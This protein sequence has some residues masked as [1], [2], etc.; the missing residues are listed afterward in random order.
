MIND[1]E[2][3]LL[4]DDKHE[5]TSDLFELIKFNTN[6]IHNLQSEILVVASSKQFTFI[7]TKKAEI[8]KYKLNDLDSLNYAYSLKPN[9][10]I[11]IPEEKK[12]KFNDDL[13]HIWTDQLGNHVIIKFEHR[14]FYFNKLLQNPFELVSLNDIEIYAVA[15]DERNKDEKTTQ[16]ILISDQNSI[17]YSYKISIEE[18]KKDFSVKE[19]Q[20]KKLFEPENISKDDRI[21]SIYFTANKRINNP[22]YYII[23]VT[24]T[25]FFQFEGK[26]DFEFVFD[27]YNHKSEEN[28]KNLEN[29]CKIFP[30]SLK[31][32]S[33]KKSDL[34]ILYDKDGPNFKHFGWLCESGFC[35]GNFKGNEVPEQVQNFVILPYVKIKKDGIRVDDFPISFCIS[36]NHIFI[37]YSDCLTVLSKIT[38]NIIHTQYFTNENF[39]GM[40]YNN[41]NDEK[42]I[43]I[44]SLNSGLYQ[45]SLKDEDKNVWQ[46]YLE[47][48]DYEK[49][50]NFCHT[51][52]P[53]IEPKICKLS[54]NE[55]FEKGDYNNA[56]IKYGLSDEKFEEVCLKFLLKNELGGLKN[57]LNVIEKTR[58][59]DKDITQKYL[60]HTWL[61]EIYLNSTSNNKKNNIEEF[62]QMVSENSKYLDKDTIYQLL[63]N[64]GRVEEFIEFAE[65]KDDYE[66]VILHYINEKDVDTAIEKLI[67]YISYCGDDEAVLKK[68][69]EIFVKFAHIFMKSNHKKSIEILQN[70][71]QKIKPEQIITA[72]MNT[73]ENNQKIEDFQDILKYL[74]ELVEDPNIKDKNIHN[75][76]IFYLS[77]S[78]D[79]YHS[80]LI[81][82]LEKPLKK[83]QNERRNKPKT[84]ILFEL[85]YAKKLFKENY[86]ALALVL[87]LMG[88]YNEGVKIALENDKNEIAKFIASNVSDEKI[89]KSLW[90]D[91]FSANKKNNFKDALE[92]MKTSQ[93]LKIEDVLPRI[94]D[95]IKI[96]EF[97]SQ[98][99]ECID[100]YEKNIKELRDDIKEYNKTAE[101][102]KNDINKVK[103]KSLEIQYRQCKCEICQCNIKDN[104]IYL[105][106]CG[107]M[108]D[109]KCI[110]DSLINYQKNMPN[111]ENLKDKVDKI[112]DLQKNINE[113]EKKFFKKQTVDESKKTTGV[114]GFFNFQTKTGK[115]NSELNEVD[116]KKLNDDKETLSE[117]LSEE[118]VLC[119]D[120]MVES[121]Q[122]NFTGDNVNWMII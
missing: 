21:Y 83:D 32:N 117:L 30:S 109:S 47:I 1:I 105:F 19:H 107:H 98:I 62:R 40:N 66:T 5:S 57:Y 81:K 27:N 96:E 54:A 13:V 14:C 108:F 64:Y 46:D 71:K 22:Y 116:K 114:F 41:F 90:L 75:L 15:F 61:I 80:E 44:Y 102:I 24:K 25:K 38:S 59:T 87:A 56:S 82:Y 12:K 76:Y 113:N 111:D 93:I 101:N 92:I 119:G 89:K 58:L 85:D 36:E 48:G 23:A 118:C 120:Y 69:S 63:Q 26:N 10:N 53:K 77:K 60:I 65:S 78:G 7:V 73:T 91:I 9:L 52:N 72:I 112:L 8:F 97:K 94:M 16:N 106:P 4:S 79:S 2:S 11:E 34:Q 18:N 84:E 55:Y 31:Q 115:D 88:K 51:Y 95:N 74:K 50:M 45:I 20:R 3:N 17:I 104:N 28:Q 6:N 103:K 121:T 68:L 33:L 39:V 29:C 70:L 35:F 67:S 37:L 122:C 100:V 42:F 86:D 99:S 43:W 49:A 110:I